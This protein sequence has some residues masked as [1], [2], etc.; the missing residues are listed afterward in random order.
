VKELPDAMT[1]MAAKEPDDF[2]RVTI[3][4]LNFLVTSVGDI[5]ELLLFIW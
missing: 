3:E 1:A 5:D 2:K 4:Y